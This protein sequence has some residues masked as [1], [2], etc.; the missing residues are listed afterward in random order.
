VPIGGGE[1]RAVLA[2]LDAGS[3]FAV[4]DEWVFVSGHDPSSGA[5]VIRRM[6]ALGGA[7]S[8]VARHAEQP[9]HLA[10]HDAHVY[11]FTCTQAMGFSG[12][13]LLRAPKGG[14]TVQV[15]ARGVR[16]PRQGTDAV[17][18]TDRVYWSAERPAAILSA[19]VA[20]GEA[21]VLATPQHDYAYGFASDAERLYWG[22]YGAIASVPKRGGSV[23]TIDL[24]GSC[25]GCLVVAPGL[26]V[27]GDCGSRR[28][29]R[30]PR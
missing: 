7:A 24:G 11:W 21:V 17:F 13:D 6:P 10:Q 22:R 2:S 14:G 15:V 12:G 23:D 18:D 4:D 20:G 16:R 26:I 5:Y 27:Y 8:A 29:V 25:A 19:P 28:V 3:S 1:P 30:L 9:C